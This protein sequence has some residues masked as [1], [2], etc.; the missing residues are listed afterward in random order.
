M[1][2]TVWLVRLWDTRVDG[3][4]LATVEAKKTEQYPFPSLLKAK[5]AQPET[6]LR[7]SIPDWM[8]KAYGHTWLSLSVVPRNSL[9]LEEHRGGD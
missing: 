6:A 3:I 2:V 1:P 8:T 5:D 9:R 4:S 7:K